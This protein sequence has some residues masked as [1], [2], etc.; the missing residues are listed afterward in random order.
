MDSPFI[1]VLLPVRNEKNRISE[2]LASIGRQ[3]LPAGQFE[4]LAIDGMSDDGTREVLHNLR[5]NYANLRIVDNPRKSVSAAL[6]I[7]IREA[8]GEFLVRCDAHAFYSS[9]YLASCLGVAVETGAGNVGGHA[10]PLPGGTT[11][12]AWAIMLAHESSFGLGGA[13]FRGEEHEGYVETVWPGCYRK[14]LFE[15]VGG[16]NELLPRS[17]DIDLNARLADAG[18]TCYLSRRIKAWYYCRPDLA[19]LFC[20]RLS[21]GIGIA[22]TLFVNQRAVKSRHLIPLVF[23]SSLIMLAGLSVH[24]AARLLFAVELSLYGSASIYFAGRSFVA[25]SGRQPGVPEDGRAVTVKKPGAAIMLPIV[26]GALHCAYG[27]G[28]IIGLATLPLFIRKSMRLKKAL[29]TGAGSR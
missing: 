23:I 25:E 1:S 13:R 3:N 17:E 19:S 15:K 28:T 14:K 10:R 27:V 20:Q 8:K 12:M 11:L 22:R 29:A 26:F 9:D 21:D 18:Y 16:Y 4:L 24:P 6:N 2:C 7:G 5:K